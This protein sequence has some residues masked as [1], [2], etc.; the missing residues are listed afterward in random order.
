MSPWFSAFLRPLLC[1]PLPS[2]LIFSNENE[3]ECFVSLPFFL[4]FFFLS[5]PPFREPNSCDTEMI[6]NL[7]VVD[8]CFCL[9]VSFIAGVCVCVRVCVRVSWGGRGIDFTFSRKSP[10]CVCLFVFLTF[11]K[12]IPLC[13]LFFVVVVLLGNPSI[14]KKRGIFVG[15]GNFAWKIPCLI[16]CIFPFLLGNPLISTKRDTILIY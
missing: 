4:S 6:R 3:F 11:L 15:L 2:L 13:Y 5:D 12:E 1:P 9:F 7:I 8:C 10:G 16:F 14:S